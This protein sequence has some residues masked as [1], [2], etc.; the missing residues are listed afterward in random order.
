MLPIFAEL[1]NVR[2]WGIGEV[3]VAIVIIAACVGIMYIA[4]RQFQ[5]EIPQFVIQIFWIVVVAIL[6]IAAIRFILTL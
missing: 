4:L 2:T 6:A 3:L 5:V 1:N